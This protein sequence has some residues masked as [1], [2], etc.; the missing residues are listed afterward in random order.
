TELCNF[1]QLYFAALDL[2]QVAVAVREPITIERFRRPSGGCD[3]VWHNNTAQNDERKAAP[4]QRPS[5][6]SSHF[7]SLFKE[8]WMGRWLS[9][10]EQAYAGR[11]EGANKSSSFTSLQ[12]DGFRC[13]EPICYESSRQ[14]RGDQCISRCPFPAVPRKSGTAFRHT[15]GCSNLMQ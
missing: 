11:R 13:F 10:R 12:F 6:W 1:I 2:R 8:K 15:S 4:R 5:L 9:V 3:K 7:A 14:G